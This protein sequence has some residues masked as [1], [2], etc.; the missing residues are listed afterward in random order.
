MTAKKSK[1]T[2]KPKP[3]VP[4]PQ[5]VQEATMDARG[6]KEGSRKGKVHELYD[7][8]GPEVAFVLGQKLKLKDGTLRSWF[9]TWRR[10]DKKPAKAKAE[11]PVTKPEAAAQAAA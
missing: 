11:K 8:Q 2:P 6:H 7:K 5:P 10:L 3:K 9:G 4:A 1:P